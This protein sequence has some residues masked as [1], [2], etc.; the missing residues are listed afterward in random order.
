[1]ADQTSRGG[2]KAGNQNPT[3]PDQ[4]RG[5]ATAGAGERSYKDKQQDQR[6]NPDDS[7]RRPVDQQR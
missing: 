1:M 3:P 6:S 4:H 7:A 5:A 2:Q